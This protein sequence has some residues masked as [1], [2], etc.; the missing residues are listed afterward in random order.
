MAKIPK[1][2]K[3]CNKFNKDFKM[4]H[5]EKKIL[6]KKNCIKEKVKKKSEVTESCLFATPWT[7]AHQAPWSMGFSRHEY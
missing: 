7:V 2:K 4:V 5:I 3:Y 1:Q 6:K